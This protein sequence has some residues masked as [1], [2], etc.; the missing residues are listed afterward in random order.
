MHHNV[1]ARI[2]A[3]TLSLTN[4]LGIRIANAQGPVEFALLIASDDAIHAFWHLVIA[5]KKLRSCAA[6]S[7]C[8]LIDFQ[9]LT[10]LEKCQRV[11]FFVNHDPIGLSVC[12]YGHRLS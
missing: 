6:T 7:Q 5:S 8:Y 10:T 1:I 3:P 9:D 2:D 12:C 11:R 4:L